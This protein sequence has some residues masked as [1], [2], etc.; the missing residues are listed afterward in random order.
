MKRSFIKALGWKTGTCLFFSGVY[1]RS[2]TVR[3]FVS[4]G[5][6]LYKKVSGLHPVRTSS[7]WLGQVQQFSALGGQAFVLQKRGICLGYAFVWAEADALWAQEMVCV[8][9]P[10]QQVFAQLLM[11]RYGAEHIK[12]TGLPGVEKT[13]IAMLKAHTNFSV[14][15]GY[16][17]LLWN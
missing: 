1:N 5:R 14:Q 15:K 13:P 9:E 7:D 11:Q 2:S 8:H 10:D 12:V 4:N 16:L 6:D 17:N 3:P